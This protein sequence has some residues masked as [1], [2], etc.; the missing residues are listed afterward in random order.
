MSKLLMCKVD[1]IE[2]SGHKKSG[3][4]RKARNPLLTALWL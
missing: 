4:Q 2:L 3:L 1:K